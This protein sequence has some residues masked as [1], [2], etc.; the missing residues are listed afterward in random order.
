MYGIPPCIIDCVGDSK[1]LL[2]RRIVM[3]QFRGA[4]NIA[5]IDVDPL[6]AIICSADDNIFIRSFDETYKDLR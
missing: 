4:N 5:L 3:R 2:G 1:S 6:S